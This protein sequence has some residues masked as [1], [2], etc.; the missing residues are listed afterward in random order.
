MLEQDICINM[1]VSRSQ[2]ILGHTFGHVRTDA[3]P[4]LTRK[5]TTTVTVTVMVDYNTPVHDEAE[6][7]YATFH[8][9]FITTTTMSA[10]LYWHLQV[11]DS[12]E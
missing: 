2:N 5:I 6:M 8:V 7:T 12:M 4:E 1:H 3:N 11:I 10:T 9:L